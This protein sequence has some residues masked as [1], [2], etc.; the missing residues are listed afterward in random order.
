MIAVDSAE[1]VGELGEH[2]R[3]LLVVVDV[4]GG[5]RD[6]DAGV[7][8][9]QFGLELVEPVGAAGAQRQVAALRGE[10]AGHTRAQA[11]ARAGDQDLLPSHR[12]SLIPGCQRRTLLEQP[13]H[14][15][16]GQRPCRRSDRSGSTGTTC[17][18]TT[19]HARCRRTPGTAD[20]CG[21]AP[22]API[23]SPPSASRPAGRRNVR[24]RR[25][26][27]RSSRRAGP[28]AARRSACPRWR[29]ATAWR[30]AGSRR[31][32][33]CRCRRSPSGR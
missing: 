4:Q 20:R 7:T 22:A 21:R 19:P 32:R 29:T 15:P 24:R 25:S 14:P 27:P 18:R 1:F 26:A 33:R 13:R 17:R 12:H 31:C 16:V 8:L 11:R 28:P 30:R 5:D 3:H 2:L 10:C 9:E 6:G 23:A